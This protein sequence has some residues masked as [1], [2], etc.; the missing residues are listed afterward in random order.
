MVAPRPR[1]SRQPA[2]S[3][4]TVDLTTRTNVADVDEV[5][6]ALDREDD[7][8]AADPRASATIATLQRLGVRA[9]RIFGDLIKAG[10]DAAVGGLWQATKVTFCWSC[11][12]DGEPHWSPWRCSF[13]SA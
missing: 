11:D 1:Q 9:V 6:L 2:R 10:Q 12:T 4:P 8:Q 7:P 13:L 5:P 3:Q